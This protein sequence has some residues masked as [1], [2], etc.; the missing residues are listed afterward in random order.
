MLAELLQSIAECPDID[1][2]LCTKRPENFRKQLESAHVHVMA[3]TPTS[4]MI[5]NWLGSNYFGHS[6]KPPHNV[7]ILFSAEDQE[8]Y[9]KRIVDACL[10]PAVRRGVSIEPMIGPVDLKLN[11]SPLLNCDTTLAGLL[12]WIIV[13]GESGKSRVCDCCKGEGKVWAPSTYPPRSA[14]H[15][16]K[17]D[18]DKCEGTGIMN[19][20]RPC[21]L[22]WIDDVRIQAGNFN[23]PTFIKQ[24]GSIC[25]FEN[26]NRWEFPDHQMVNSYPL[27]KTAS[28]G[29]MLTRHDKGGDSSEWP[30]TFRVQQSYT[31]IIL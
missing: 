2:I 27:I 25:V 5:C 4:L 24:V 9:D 18:C 30:S 31:P 6:P 15:R 16:F 26:G 14:E 19:A 10:I 29:R 12:H 23:I 28:G 21:F 7:I 1:F 8:N 17:I 22:E 3:G 20:P 13:G 11:R